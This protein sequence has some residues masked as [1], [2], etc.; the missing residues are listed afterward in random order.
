LAC[1]IPRAGKVPTVPWA[2][3]T[4]FSE[5][6]RV[7]IGGVSLMPLRLVLAYAIIPGGSME[8]AMI[9]IAPSATH[10]FRM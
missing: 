7:R 9:I 1:P 10:G 2:P 8:I 6:L 3:A 4:V 5:A